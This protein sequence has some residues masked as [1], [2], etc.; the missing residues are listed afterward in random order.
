MKYTDK[1]KVKFNDI[2]K[3]D[4]QLLKALK[5]PR[6]YRAR[7]E[8]FSRARITNFNIYCDIAARH[9]FNKGYTQD[10]KAYSKIMQND[11]GDMGKM[12]LSFITHL[13]RVTNKQI[14]G[15]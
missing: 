4:A 15:L 2:M 12:W 10:L 14:K 7:D 3:S 9:I 13:E 1:Q 5:A 11:L 8:S 6:F